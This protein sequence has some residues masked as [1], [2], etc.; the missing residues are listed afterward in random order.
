MDS[1]LDPVLRPLQALDHHFARQFAAR[2]L[3]H[4]AHFDGAAVLEDLLS[5]AEASSSSS[6]SSSSAAAAASQPLARIP[7]LQTTADNWDVLPGQLVR[8]VGMVQ[9]MLEP[10]YFS[11]AAR[12]AHKATG[13][14]RVVSGKYRDLEGLYIGGGEYELRGEVDGSLA[15]RQVL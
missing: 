11:A 5:T 6:S 12:V 3:A 15:S 14:E 4:A 13:A 8:F 1:S 10:E 2:E 9:D 7:L